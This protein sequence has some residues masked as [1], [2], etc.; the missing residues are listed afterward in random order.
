[1][2]NRNFLASNRNWITFREKI[3]N[4]WQVLSDNDIDRCRGHF[5]ALANI[6]ERRCNESRLAVIDYID[7]L[8]FEIYVRNSRHQF[9]QL[10]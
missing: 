10:N 9:P 5:T 6:I 3:K 1:M 7:N 4:R 8:W 2:D